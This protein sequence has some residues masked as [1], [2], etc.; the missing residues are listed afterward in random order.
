MNPI[1]WTYDFTQ[2]DWTGRLGGVNPKRSAETKERLAHIEKALAQKCVVHVWMY[3]IKHRVIDVGMREKAP[4][5]MMPC[6][7]IV[8]TLGLE[9]HPWYDCGKVQYDA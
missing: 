5:G 3:G 2:H 4:Y 1:D 6:V 9:W 7:C 8:A